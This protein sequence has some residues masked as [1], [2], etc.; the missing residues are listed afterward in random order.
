MGDED[1]S[2]AS[3]G[4]QQRDQILLFREKLAA[5]GKE[6]LFFRWVEI[7]QFESSQEGGFTLERQQS[8]MLQAKKLFEDGGVDFSSLWRE[9]GGL[10]GFTEQLD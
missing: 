10:E 8:A 5:M 3:G 2:E 7:I 9:V 6:D 1:S 4:S